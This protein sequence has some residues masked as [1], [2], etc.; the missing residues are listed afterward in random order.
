MKSKFLSNAF[1]G[2]KDFMFERG[3]KDT[4]NMLIVMGALGFALSS[5]AQ[6]FAIKT[7]DKIDNKKKNFLLMQEAADGVVNIGLFLGITS[8]IW[9]VSD[10]IL[11]L[12]GLGKMGKNQRKVPLN[13]HGKGKIKSGGRIFT[14][15][16]ASVVACN[17]IT[18]YVR[19]FIAGKI[20][21]YKDEK[22]KKAQTTV[23]NIENN[24]ILSTFEK[25]ERQSVNVNSNPYF[26]SKFGYTKNYRGSL[27][28]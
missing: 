26:N 19:N 14:T 4:A 8:G 9:K 17:I 7:N 22:A 28:I 21:K 18:P 1:E 16:A 24:D 13:P 15:L 11:R 27:K 10:K 3:R 5:L 20:I 2:F 25:F 12:I 6:C 23:T